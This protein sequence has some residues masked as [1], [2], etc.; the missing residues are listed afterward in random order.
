MR[1]PTAAF[2]LI[3]MSGFFFAGFFVVD[4]F[5]TLLFWLAFFLALLEVG[6]A[7]LTNVLS[8][9]GALFDSSCIR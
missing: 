5:L 8:G 7:S 4:V 6:I 2:L 9:G 1:Q 3:S